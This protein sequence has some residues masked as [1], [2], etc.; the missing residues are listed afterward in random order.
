[1]TT[2]DVGTWQLDGTPALATATN[3]GLLYSGSMKLIQR[4]LL[5]MLTSKG[6]VRVWPDRGTSLPSALRNGY[7]MQEGQ[8]RAAFALAELEARPK[9][10]NEEAN[11]DPNDERYKSAALTTIQVQTDAVIIQIQLTSRADTY[12]LT[13]ALPRTI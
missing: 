8:L 10:Q 9:L 2:Y 4:F 13:L 6:S 7:I 5:E 1:M 11:T 3:S 12:A